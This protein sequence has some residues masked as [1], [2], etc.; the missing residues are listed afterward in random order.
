MKPLRYARLIA[1]LIIALL[2]F[3]QYHVDSVQGATTT[4]FGL[5]STNAL[6]CS[7]YGRCSATD[8][9]T[10]NE[11]YYGNSCN[12]QYR[13]TSRTT[14]FGKKGEIGSYY[15]GLIFSSTGYGISDVEGDEFLYYID[16][17]RV[18]K[19][20]MNTGISSST[21]MGVP[22]P[23]RSYAISN[24]KCVQRKGKK[25]CYAIQDISSVSVFIFGPDSS[26]MYNTPF[27]YSVTV[28][29][30]PVRDCL[31]L[32]SRTTLYQLTNLDNFNGTNWS[33]Y[34]KSVPTDYS[35]FTV[36]TN[37]DL[38]FCDSTYKNLVKLKQDGT[39]TTLATGMNHYKGM[40][41]SNYNEIFWYEKGFMK[42]FDG[43]TFKTVMTLD[44]SDYAEFGLGR[45]NNTFYQIDNNV[46]EKLVYGLTCVDNR[47]KGDNCDEVA[48]FCNSVPFNDSKVCSGHGSCQTGE[49]CN[50]NYGYTGTDCE[51]LIITCFG[52]RASNG[53]VCSG[54]G[55]CIANDT[56]V[57]NDGYYGN[58]CHVDTCFNILGNSSSVCSGNGYCRGTDNCICYDGFAGPLCNNTV[59]TGITSFKVSDFNFPMPRGKFVS[60][61]SHLIYHDETTLEVLAISFQT[62]AVSLLGY[63]TQSTVEEMRYYNG[64]VYFIDSTKSLRFLPEGGFTQKITGS[65]TGAS[66]L[67]TATTYGTFTGEI[68]TFQVCSQG[69]IFVE[70][71]TGK[72]F[73]LVF[74]YKTGE[75]QFFHIAGKGYTESGKS[76]SFSNGN[77]KP[78]DATL[79][80]INSLLINDNG[81]LFMVDTTNHVIRQFNLLGTSTIAT[82][83]GVGTSKG[84]SGDGKSAKSSLLSLNLNST[85]LHYNGALMFFD[86]GNNLIRKVLNGILYDVAGRQTLGGAATI[87]LDN[88]KT[89]LLL[90][91]LFKTSQGDIVFKDTTG[92]YMA[93]DISLKCAEGFTG[94]KCD[95]PLKCGGR[96][97]LDPNVCSKR[98]PCLSTGVCDCP[99]G[100]T[101][102]SCEFAIC[103]NVAANDASFMSVDIKVSSEKGRCEVK[104]VNYNF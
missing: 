68:Q 53:G 80:Y 51:S 39:K 58:N 14:V 47:W 29:Y 69:I 71:N 15:K 52:A 72:I 89:S 26:I 22:D 92:K 5:A 61:E 65:I 102:D 96:S 10:C 54:R 103:F 78:L 1:A 25:F 93:L 4:C 59:S 24:I 12:K 87:G 99:Y 3:T 70:Q 55:K 27:Q 97:F 84:Y 73:K 32:Y 63:F 28:Q 46:I 85:L 38:L 64:I 13:I 100:W 57:C 50:C 18:R 81:D 56:C 36:T 21:R 20:N 67:K 60:N 74:D 30:D 43:T 33:V 7:G 77:G 8:V 90:T 37:G 45:E 41:I 94:S 2:F 48:L 104:E 75:T 23:D 31:F 95:E 62:K 101:G 76:W 79:G 44:C 34:I 88:T 16:E 82:T 9:C 19:L 6:V 35:C 83:A 98:G 66:Y 49:V 17:S 42:K 86:G 91:N 11:G 40:Y